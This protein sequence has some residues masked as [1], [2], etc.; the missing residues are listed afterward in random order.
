ME[1]QIRVSMFLQFFLIKKSNDEDIVHFMQLL[2]NSRTKC[3]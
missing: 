1:G 2:L 3:L